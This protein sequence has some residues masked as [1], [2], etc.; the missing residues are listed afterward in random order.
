MTIARFFSFLFHP[1]IMPLVGVIIL[2]QAI[3]WMGMLG[4]EIKLNIYLIVI[5]STLLLPMLSGPLLKS[6]KIITDYFMPTAEE[7]KVPLLL[8]SL[9]YMV[10]AFILQR[11]HVPL[12][13]P[14]FINSSSLVIL[15]CALI[16][17]KWKISSHM[18]IL[19][20]LVGL[21]LAISLKWMMDLRLILGILIFVSGVTG[22]ARLKL[23]THTPAQVYAGFGLG[24]T[25]VFLI[26]RFI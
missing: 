2:L 19:A 6:K 1:L 14:L 10:R 18:A 13:F 7:R 17:W 5:I 4:W 8:A 9:L 25:V 20:G 16:S 26:V 23:G 12:I 24:F 15:L 22:W 21:V 3:S 11:I